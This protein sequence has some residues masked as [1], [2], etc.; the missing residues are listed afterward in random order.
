MGSEYNSLLITKAAR[1]ISEAYVSL[2]LARKGPRPRHENAALAVIDIVS[3]F[4]NNIQ[5]HDIVAMLDD[6]E[7]Q[8]AAIRA[9]I[10]TSKAQR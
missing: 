2:S 8:L 7:T 9:H 6:I 4:A 5:E 3:E 10:V 1:E